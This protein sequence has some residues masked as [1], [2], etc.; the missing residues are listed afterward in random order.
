MAK[1]TSVFMGAGIPMYYLT[2]LSRARS[3]GKGYNRVDTDD[4]GIRATLSCEHLRT[5]SELTL[6][7][8]G[9]HSLMT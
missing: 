3:A 4:D 2:A 5:T 1:L 9:L 8:L 7:T 6:Q